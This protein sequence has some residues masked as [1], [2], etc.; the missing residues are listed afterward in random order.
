MQNTAPVI[1]K[2][3]K[4]VGGDG[5]H[6]GAWKVAIGHGPLIG[7]FRPGFSEPPIR[8]GT[9]C[10]SDISVRRRF[11]GDLCIVTMRVDPCARGIDRPLTRNRFCGP[12][13]RKSGPALVFRLLGE[14]L[15]NL[16]G[17]VVGRQPILDP[18]HLS[19]S[20]PRRLDAFDRGLEKPFVSRQRGANGLQSLGIPDDGKLARERLFPLGKFAE[21]REVS[22]PDR[23][24]F[25]R[26]KVK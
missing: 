5:H 16:S 8:G 7:R 11:C 13:W 10:P 6:G 25:T 14:D 1:I 18:G 15:V 17:L 23:R 2:R 21:C 12:M 20:F 26:Q 3:K 19:Q 22:P 4:V 9:I 24:G